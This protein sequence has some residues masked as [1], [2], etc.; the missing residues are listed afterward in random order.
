MTVF[1]Q[2]N[3]DALQTWLADFL[4]GDIAVLE[5]RHPLIV[6]SGHQ[7]EKQIHS[8]AQSYREC[9]RRDN[10]SEFGTDQRI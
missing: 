10:E 6:R 1:I 5:R 4:S 9:V 3:K 2:T 7:P 8:D